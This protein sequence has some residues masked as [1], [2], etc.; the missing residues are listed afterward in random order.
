MNRFFVKIERFLVNLLLIILILIISFQIIMRDESAYQQV[1]KLEYTVKGLLNTKDT[2]EVTSIKEMEKKAHLTIDL[3]HDYSLPQVYLI[4]NG[5]RV[6]NFSNGVVRVEVSNGDFISID[7]TV[8][9]K[10]LWFEI[11]YLSPSISNF[12]PGQQFRVSGN[13]KN[14]GVIEFYNKI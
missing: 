5:S 3:L 13:I 4:Q 2:V 9:K 10:P 7:A 6:A 8:F 14:L 11:T 1:K 12:K